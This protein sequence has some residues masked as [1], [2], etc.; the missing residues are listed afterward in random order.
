KT[1]LK[2]GIP[3]LLSSLATS[4]FVRGN[5]IMVKEIAGATANGYFAAASRISTLWSFVPDTLVSSA[6]PVISQ[7]KL[8]GQ[9]EYE[10]KLVSFVRICSL[11]GVLRAAAVSFLAPYVVPLLFGLQYRDATGI[12]IIQLWYTLPQAINASTV[13]WIVNEGLAH[14]TFQKTVTQ[15]VM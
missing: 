15:A 3:F 6:M 1:S 7:A 13:P 8:A 12:L 10:R 14:I 2:E 4:A 5:Q 9:G 11:V